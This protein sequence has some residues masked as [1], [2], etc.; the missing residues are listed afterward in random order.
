[1]TVSHSLAH[2]LSLS[3]SLSLSPFLSLALSFSLSLH[4]FLLHSTPHEQISRASSY[5][6]ISQDLRYSRNGTV[7]VVNLL[8]ICLAQRP[9]FGNCPF[10]GKIL[11]QDPTSSCSQL[12][13]QPL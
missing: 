2:L 12:F 8:H 4:R 1:M 7:P 9:E 6:Q 5:G 11:V 13:I 3:L 10:E